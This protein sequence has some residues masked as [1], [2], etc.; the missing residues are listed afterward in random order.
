[1]KGTEDAVKLGQKGVVLR[2]RA[3]GVGHGV[4]VVAVCVHL[5]DDGAIVHGVLLGIRHALQGGAAI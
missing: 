1:M 4:A 3:A 2:A 5:Q